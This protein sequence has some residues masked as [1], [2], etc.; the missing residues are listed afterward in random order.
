[1]NSMALVRWLLGRVLHAVAPRTI[2]VR[3]AGK[4]QIKVASIAGAVMV[5]AVPWAVMGARR[6]ALAI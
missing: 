6:A 5:A 4:A 3:L 1:M 2:F